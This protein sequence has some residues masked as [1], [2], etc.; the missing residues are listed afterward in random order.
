M[1]I[2]RLFQSIALQTDSIIQL[3]ESAT[4]HVARVLRAKMGDPII[5]FNGK[6]GEYEG[7]INQITK[8]NRFRQN[9]I[10]F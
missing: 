9:K 1:A 7:V 6:G 8:K 10:F 4:H 5:I 3:D 2:P